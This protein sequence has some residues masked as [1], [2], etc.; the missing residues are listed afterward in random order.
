MKWGP[1][2]FPGTQTPL[3]MPGGGEGPRLRVPLLSGCPPPPRKLL[4]PLPAFPAFLGS[5][6]LELTWEGTR[7]RETTG[8]A[9]LQ[10]TAAMGRGLGAAF[11]ICLNAWVVFRAGAKENILQQFS[12][13]T[14]E[15]GKAAKLRV[16]LEVGSTP[17]PLPNDFCHPQDKRC[18]QSLLMLDNQVPIPL[19]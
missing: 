1:L 7:H 17:P 8:H 13:E 16:G 18:F 4:Q 15:V 2:G 5:T 12:W 3:S 11:C 10:D 19:P 14:T 9:W 6:C